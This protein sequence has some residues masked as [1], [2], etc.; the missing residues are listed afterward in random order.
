MLIK[1]AWILIYRL[2][3]FIFIAFPFVSLTP[4]DWNSKYKPSHFF[5][6]LAKASTP[7]SSSIHLPSAKK[8][9]PCL[10]KGFT[11]FSF[12]AGFPGRLSSSLSSLHNSSRPFCKNFISFKKGPDRIKRI[13]RWCFNLICIYLSPRYWLLVPFPF[14]ISSLF[15][16]GLQIE[17]LF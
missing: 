5:D 12:G 16:K 9:G 3:F 15:Q 11:G 7:V 10:F 6:P 17:F 8:R 14:I 1:I 13:P 4:L 2:R